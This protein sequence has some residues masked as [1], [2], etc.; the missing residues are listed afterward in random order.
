MTDNDDLVRRIERL[1]GQNRRLTVAI[2]VALILIVALAMMPYLRT[3][4]AVVTEDIRLIDASG[5]TRA[6]LGM[7]GDEPM[8]VFYDR[9]GGTRAAFNTEVIALFDERSGVFRAGLEAGGLQFADSNGRVRSEVDWETVRFFD[10]NSVPCS[11]M[12][13]GSIAFHG[14]PEGTIAMFGSESLVF[15]GRGADG[16]RFWRAPN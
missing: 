7:S 16:G 4:S 14:D 9:A 12:N 8:L 13:E 10:E 3:A 5:A 2:A 6:Q 11:L 15:L 1:E